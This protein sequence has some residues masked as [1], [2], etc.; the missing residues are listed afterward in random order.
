MKKL[1]LLA[2]LLTG[3]ILQAQSNAQLKAHFQGYYEAMQKQGDVQGVIQAL[4]HLNVLE[5]STARRDTL[6]MIYANNNQHMQA[7]NTVGVELVPTDSDMAV[8]VKAI[9]L[10]AINQLPRAIAQFEELY[11]RK[12]NAYLA[13]ELADLKIQTGKIDEAK[14]N[15][16]YGMA[17]AKED[18]QYAFYERQQP[19][20]V[21]L[22]AA[23]KHLEALTVFNKDKDVDKAIALMDEA[24]AIAPHFNL[25]S[26]SKQALE[27][28]KEQP[29]GT[30]QE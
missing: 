6:A 23:F 16:E 13:Y 4:T 19:Y 10:K 15:I 20:Q 29:E 26:L 2:F 24:L 5:P 27:K 12:P 17:N 11:K 7:L 9:S 21:P 14:A 22:K 3:T 28:R 25:A 18:D 1:L 30:T 8:Q